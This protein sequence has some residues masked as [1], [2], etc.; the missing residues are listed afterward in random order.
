MSRQAIGVGAAAND[1]TGDPLRTA[2][3]KSNDNFSEIYTLLGGDTLTV[4]SAV[5]ALGLGTEDSPTFTGLTLSGLTSGRVP[6]VGTGGLFTDSANLTFDGTTFSTLRASLAAGTLTTAVG[7]LT[8]TETR[9]AA[10]VTFPGL[11]YTITDTAS[12]AGSLALQILGG[13]AGATSLLSIGKS[14]LVT[15]GAT[16]GTFGN[17]AYGSRTSVPWSSIYAGL[18]IG[19]FTCFSE[20]AEQANTSTNWSINANW[21][22]SAWQYAL[23]GVAV[24]NYFQNQGTHN[25]RVAGSGTMGNTITWTTALSIASDGAVQFGGVTTNGISQISSGVLGVGTGAA[26]SFAGR[27]KLTS[28]IAAGVAVG[29]LNAAPTTGEVQS[30]TDALAPAVGVQVAAGGAA[31]ALVWYNGAQWTVIGI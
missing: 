12:A 14:A 1:G 29:S 23:S 19:S 27:L 7:P 5:S 8:I 18:T 9:N 22:G 17:I 28:A 21:T 2:F 13:A 31:K 20:G 24:S 3:Q 25:F 4:S 11:K 15:I 26:G 30:V 10:G 6:T 16:S